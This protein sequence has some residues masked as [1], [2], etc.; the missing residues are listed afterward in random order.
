M[1]VGE[2]FRVMHLTLTVFPMAECFQQIVTKAVH[3]YNL[4]VHRGSL[5]VVVQ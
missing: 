5:P 2:N 1:G 4:G 3:E